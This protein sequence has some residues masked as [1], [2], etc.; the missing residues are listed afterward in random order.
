M[1]EAQ[2]YKCLLV[3]TGYILHRM[4]RGIPLV[5]QKELQRVSRVILKEIIP[6]FGLPRFLQSDNGSSVTARITQ[7]LAQVLGISYH[8]H[9]SWRPQFSGKVKKVNHCLKKNIAK[10][11]QE[12]SE[13]GIRAL[14]IALLQ[15]KTAPKSNLQ[16][17]PYEML[18]ERPF[19]ASD[20]LV[21]T[22]VQ[23]ITRNIINW[24]K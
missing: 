21:D 2:I 9:A 4:D 14:P 6:W 10:L 11:C 1:T 23:E 24:D 5:G 17:S 22:E 13:S 18:Y 20:F 12:A 8:F 15:V 16:F 3:L 19:L 7:W